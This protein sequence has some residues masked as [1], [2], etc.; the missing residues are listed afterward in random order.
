[1]EDKYAGSKS[2]SLD[3]EEESSMNRR[4]ISLSENKLSSSN[5]GISSAIGDNDGGDGDSEEGEE[6]Q[7]MI[8]TAASDPSSI[9][10]KDQMGFSYAKLDPS[11]QGKGMVSEVK[12]LLYVMYICVYIYIYVCICLLLFMVLF[13][14][15]P[16][17]LLLRRTLYINVSV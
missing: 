12:R 16:A 7:H 9:Q 2:E 4:H 14:P 6:D 10:K 5:R 8:F 11:S 3:E 1:M 13:L 17:L 15:P